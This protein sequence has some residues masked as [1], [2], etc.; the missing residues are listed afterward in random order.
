MSSGIYKITNTI[1][2]KV[3]IGSAIDIKQRFRTHK[4]LL[5]NNKHFNNHLQASWNKHKEY[6]F[7]FEVLE[8]CLLVR[9]DL[10]NKEQYYIDLLECC[11][12]LK[13]YN[14]K[15]HASSSLGIKISAQGRL[16][17]SIGQKG[18]KQSREAVERRAAKMR[19]HTF[20]KGIKRTP[21]FCKRVAEFHSKP[22]LQ[23]TLKGKFIKEF[24]SIKDAAESLNIRASGISAVCK[25]KR[26]KCGDY[27]FLYKNGVIEDVITPRLRKNARS[28]EHLCSNVQNELGEFSGSLVE[29][30]TELSANLND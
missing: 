24:Y 8:Y 6:A 7:T 10:I 12:P 15:P 13:G 9:E 1:N 29:D 16:N 18:K 11:N 25:G 5:K 26:T 20:N 14:K 3:Y 27:C 4:H 21:E 2:G 17:M 28:N 30:N 19:G 23:Y 22:V